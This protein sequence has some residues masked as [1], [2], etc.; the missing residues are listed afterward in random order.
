MIFSQSYTRI[1]RK[2]VGNK[3]TFNRQD[4]EIKLFEDKVIT[5]SHQFPIEDVWDISFKRMSGQGF[6]YLHTTSGVY[7]FVTEYD[8]CS[9]IE[10]YKKLKLK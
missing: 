4:E 7:S 3:Q 1:S 5:A 6:L 8:P 2:V 9:F 10:A